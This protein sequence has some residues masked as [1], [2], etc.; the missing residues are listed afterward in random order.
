[1]PGMHCLPDIAPHH[2]LQDRVTSN[3]SIGNK[4]PALITVAALLCGALQVN[5]S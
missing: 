1:M 4:S 5:L 3:D 2:S